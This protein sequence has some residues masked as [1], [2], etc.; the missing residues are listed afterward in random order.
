MKE[1]IHS[2]L[3]YS[4]LCSVKVTGSKTITSSPKVQQQ[5]SS[6]NQRTLLSFS[7]VIQRFINLSSTEN[8]SN[9]WE[10]IILRGIIEEDYVV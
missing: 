7:E 1:K 6:N 5:S 2:V 3:V 4:E 8:S 10:Y 9:R